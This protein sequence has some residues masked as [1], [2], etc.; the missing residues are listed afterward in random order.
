[1]RSVI[2]GKSKTEPLPDNIVITGEKL[3]NI[4]S[5]SNFRSYRLSDFKGILKHTMTGMELD[6]I[7]SPRILCIDQ[8]S[9]YL[10]LSHMYSGSVNGLYRIRKTDYSIT[11]VANDVGNFC[12]DEDYIYMISQS[13]NTVRILNKF[14][15][16]YITPTLPTFSGTTPPR[17]IKVDSN[18]LYVGGDNV[19]KILNKKTFVV[20]TNVTPGTNINYI[21][22]DKYDDIVYFCSESG[23]SNYFFNTKT[24]Q[25]RQWYKGNGPIYNMSSDQNYLYVGGS[26]TTFNSISRYCFCIISKI[27]Y[28][29]PWSST[30]NS[31]VHSIQ[32]DGDYIYL[33][34]GFTTLGGLECY[35]FGMLKK[36]NFSRY[37]PSD[38]TLPQFINTAVYTNISNM[39]LLTSKKIPEIG[40]KWIQTNLTSLDEGELRMCHNTDCSIALLSGGSS[41]GIFISTDKGFNWNKIPEV[42]TYTVYSII[43]CDTTSN[44][45]EDSFFIA[46]MYDSV[47][48][49]YSIYKSVDGVVWTLLYNIPYF[50][51]DIGY[52]PSALGNANKAML[53]WINPDKNSTTTGR[54]IYYI[55]GDWTLGSK[56]VGFNVTSMVYNKWNDRYYVVGS[57][58]YNRYDQ[59]FYHSGDGLNFEFG[60]S[61][62]AVYN[63]FLTINVCKN[64]LMIISNSNS[65]GL[66]YSTPSSNVSP[67]WANFQRCPNVLAIQYRSYS[68][69]MVQVGSNIFCTDA[70]P[71]SKFS[72]SIDGIN[73]VGFDNEYLPEHVTDFAN[74]GDEALLANTNN[75]LWISTPY[76]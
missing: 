12:L 28:T 35:K 6:S 22:I 58:Y 70:I 74:I 67:N 8:D 76:L 20:V 30:P 48:D 2:L 41:N 54:Q 47:A 23:T 51:V 17:A 11:L 69:F 57:Y 26:F 34:G 64:S 9:E 72:K 37:L 18:Y 25:F 56:N 36:S 52:N 27:D 13:N 4:T 66:F 68:Y 43:F 50:W 32:N 1:M 63:D 46:H 15:N 38:F 75:G 14:T 49:T 33:G 24:L 29:F 59:Y 40:D 44:P 39:L 61:I 3:S 16:T 65:G 73:W 53:F 7:Y 55:K 19:I 31:N 71:D 42:E 45:V 10:Y 62:S 60:Q 21:F 5:P